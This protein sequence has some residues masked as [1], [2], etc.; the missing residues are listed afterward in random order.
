MRPRPPRSPLFPYTTLFRSDD[1]FRG[2]DG[3]PLAYSGALVDA[4]IFAGDERNLLDHLAHELGNLQLQAVARRPRFLRG[5]GN[6]FFDGHRIMRANLGA[7]A[8][9]QRRND[10]AARGVIL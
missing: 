6:A 9:L 8:V 1:V 10:F 2:A 5:D 3:Q 7:D 4:L